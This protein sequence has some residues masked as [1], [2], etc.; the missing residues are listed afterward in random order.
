MFGLFK[1]KKVFEK[2]AP[3]GD[4]TIENQNGFS[5][6]INEDVVDSYFNIMCEDQNQFV[7]L[8]A[9]K[10]INSVR[11]VQIAMFDSKFDVQIGVEEKGG[12]VLYS[13]E[14]SKN[15]ARY[16]IMDFYKGRFEPNYKSFK[17]LKM[18]AEPVPN[19]MS[20]LFSAEKARLGYSP[21]VNIVPVTVNG[22][23]I[24]SPNFGYKIKVPKEF[25]IT[26][27]N[28]ADYDGEKPYTEF[29]AVNGNVLVTVYVVPCAGETFA[30]G[31]NEFNHERI[32]KAIFERIHP[33]PNERSIEFVK[34]LGLPCGHMEGII[35]RKFQ[36][37][38]RVYQEQYSYI[39]PFCQICFYVSCPATKMENAAKLLKLFKAI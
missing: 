7:T 39:A 11:Y 30:E 16:Y 5:V 1:K 6:A 29:K 32:L 13:N 36:N 28:P 25:E 9:P 35:P 4:F 14:C 21:L 2:V 18:V 20:E 26:V 17:P 34:F 3:Q 23:E 33:F 10:A 15:E 8:T 19:K 27:G 31:K 22:N 37:G 24:V 12:T 38:I